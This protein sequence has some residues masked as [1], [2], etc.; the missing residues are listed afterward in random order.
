M[1]L[2]LPNYAPTRN[3]DTVR[4]LKRRV[5]ATEKAPIHLKITLSIP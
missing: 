2:M 1:R 5:L 3:L 4:F